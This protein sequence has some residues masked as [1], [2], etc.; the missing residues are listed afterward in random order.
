MSIP[1][2]FHPMDL[3]SC[4]VHRTRPFVCGMQRQVMPLGSR[5]KVIPNPSHFHLTDLVSCLAHLTTPFVSGTQRCLTLSPHWVPELILN[6]YHLVGRLIRRLRSYFGFHRGL[7][8]VYVFLETRWPFHEMDPPPSSILA[9]SY[10]ERLGR[11]AG[12]IKY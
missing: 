11:D 7:G 2:H 3:V 9:R 12:Q 8:R 6:F 4:L 5:L 1:S 10:T